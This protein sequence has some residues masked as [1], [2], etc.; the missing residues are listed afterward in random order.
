VRILG[1]LA[2]PEAIS[3]V[4][5]ATVRIVHHVLNYRVKCKKIELRRE[6]RGLISGGQ[7]SKPARARHS[8][9]RARR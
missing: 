7:P 3:A 6:E 9:R 8:R 1:W 4:S 5:F 2:T